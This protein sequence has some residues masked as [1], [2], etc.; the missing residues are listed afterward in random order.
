MTIGRMLL[1]LVGGLV[2]LLLLGILADRVLLPW[3]IHSQGEVLAPELVGLDEAAARERAGEL[4]L[5][6][7]V[8]DRIHDETTGPGT[9]LSQEPRPADRL[10]QGR[11]VRVVLS[12]GER[13]VAVP[14][15]RGLSQ[16]QA[17]LVLSR[18]GLV[19]GRIARSHELTRSG[20]VAAQRPH[21]GRELRAGEPV[22]I[23]LRR[24]G[25]RPAHLVPPLVGRSLAEVR[26]QLDRA[27]FELRQVRY[28]RDD[29]RWPGTVLEQSPPAGSR[30][31]LGGSLELVASTRG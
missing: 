29:D 21:A 28:R 26:D 8:G 2:G 6:V 10:R 3:I 1:G 17:E 16:R 19:L 15:L 7:V 5:R 24:G 30:I 4:G 27:G 25:E 9:V 12:L 11:P 22:D 23:M 18:E 14:D 13:R 20:G 31:P